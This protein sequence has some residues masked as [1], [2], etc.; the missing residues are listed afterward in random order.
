M[1]AVAI[2][3]FSANNHTHL[4]AEAISEGVQKA[5]HQAEL[6]RITGDQ[7]SEG[8]WKDDAV[9]EKL[10]AA[11]AIVFG[12]PT[13]MGGVA[14]QF[15]AFIDAA[16][17]VWFAQGWKD[18]I[19]AGFTHSSSLSGDKQGTLIY[20]AINAAQHSMT[21]INAGDMPSHYLG[22]SDGINRLGA[23]MGVMGQSPM[24]SGDEEAQLDAG[25]RLTCVS[26]GD[27]IAKAT[28]RWMAAEE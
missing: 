2:V 3:Y 5:G 12:S 8:R 9:M 28:Q 16:S 22:K 13:Y 11:D 27:R 23:F 24:V 10:N 7:M 26:F 25:D 19:A 18:K 21:W 6:L 20:M 4:M 17:E 14:A 1:R 15:K